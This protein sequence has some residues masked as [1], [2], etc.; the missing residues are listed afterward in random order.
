MNDRSPTGGEVF[1]ALAV[2]CEP[3]HPGHPRVAAAAGLADWPSPQASSADLFVLDLLPY[4]AIYLGP[5][6]ML[7]GVTVER[8]AGFWSALGYDPPA[9]PDHLAAL[10]GLY[11]ALRDGESGPGTDGGDL[12]VARRL[13]MGH[14]RRTLLWE[15]LLSWV[16]AFTTAVTTAGSPPHAAWGRLLRTLL[17]QEAVDLF[18]GSG[19]PGQWPVPASLREVPA[20]PGPEDGVEAFLTA[21]LAPACSGVVLTRRD[22]ATCAADLGLGLRMGGRRFVLLRLLD[23]DAGAVLAWLSRHAAWWADE[24]R[25]LPRELGAIAEHWR[26]RADATV[27]ALELRLR[28]VDELLV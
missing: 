25:R 3:A 21:V 22:L 24:H 5:E 10:L 2:L 12:A 6:G 27:A 14:A 23:S 20:L 9:E 11:A 15:H 7:G 28:L 8:I 26:V 4:A 1:R 17:L 19:G 16:P 13:L 18:G